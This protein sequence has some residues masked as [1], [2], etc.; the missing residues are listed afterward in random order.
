VKIYLSYSE[1]LLGLFKINFHL[2][3]Q[4]FLGLSASNFFNMGLS[5]TTV[6]VFT[7][8]QRC[9]LFSGGHVTGW[10]VG[11]SNPGTGKRFTSS[12]SHPNW[13]WGT[14]RLIFNG[15]CAGTVIV[16]FIKRVILAGAIPPLHQIYFHGMCSDFTFTSVLLCLNLTL[17]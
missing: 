1:C 17:Y 4:V 10:P 16:T 8:Q 11:D 6:S 15:W 12:P 7:T 5:K 14:F 9:C 13:P 3:I 2:T